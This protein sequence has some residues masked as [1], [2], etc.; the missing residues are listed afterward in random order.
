MRDRQRGYNGIA[1]PGQGSMHGRSTH[2]SGGARQGS[3]NR[4]CTLPYAAPGSPV[5]GI[6]I[7][8]PAL[9]WLRMTLC[10]PGL[11]DESRD[12]ICHVKSPTDSATPTMGLLELR[13]GRRQ[14]LKPGPV[15]TAAPDPALRPKQTPFTQRAKLCR[16]PFLGLGEP[17]VPLGLLA[18]HPHR[19]SAAQP[20]LT[21]GGNSRIV[22]LSCILIMTGCDDDKWRALPPPGG[23]PSVV[24]IQ[25]ARRSWHHTRGL[26]VLM[27]GE[28]GEYPSHRI[29]QPVSCSPPVRLSSLCQS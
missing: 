28:F 23:L 5:A 14:T 26:A 7:S 29:I 20:F 2:G 6:G 22:E 19:R 1:K 17:I 8:R 18:S 3:G 27:V 4:E 12:L 21:N 15:P 25:E 9:W 10:G 13:N 24:L 11:S 16:M